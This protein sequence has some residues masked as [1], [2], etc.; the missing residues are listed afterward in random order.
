MD[1][2]IADNEHFTIEH[3]YDCALPG[4]LIVSPKVTVTS[5][6]EL[7]RQHLGQLGFTLATAIETIHSIIKPLRV[8]C[9]QFG[10]LGTELHFHLFPRTAAIT[11]AFLRSFP[12]QAELIHGP[13][14]LDW[15]RSEYHSSR[16]ELWPVV[17]ETI[18]MMR[19]HLNRD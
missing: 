19:K 17:S 16:E 11:D 15:A 12:E 13:V 18:S 10:E 8:Y 3:C 14:L 9:A 5:I 6:H 7:P 2:L 1:F 4:Y